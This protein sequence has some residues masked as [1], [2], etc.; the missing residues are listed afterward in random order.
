MWP[1][2]SPGRVISFRMMKEVPLWLRSFGRYRS[3]SDDNKKGSLS[4]DNHGR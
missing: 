4:D 1:E 2:V 3:L